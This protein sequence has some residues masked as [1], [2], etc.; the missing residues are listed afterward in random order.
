MGEIISAEMT[1]GRPAKP[2]A[3]KNV[4]PGRTRKAG[5]HPGFTRNNEFTPER[6]TESLPSHPGWISFG[7]EFPRVFSR[8]RGFDPGLHS[9]SP[10]GWSSTTN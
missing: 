9:V 5:E 1:L 8:Y 7:T 10:P 3:W 6:V 2:E 4:A